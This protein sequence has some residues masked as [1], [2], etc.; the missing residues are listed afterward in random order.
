VTP[1][2]SDGTLD[3]RS[4]ETGCFEQRQS[5]VN[6]ELART[7][8]LHEVIGRPGLLSVPPQV[9]E[10]FQRPDRWKDPADGFKKITDDPHAP[11]GRC[12]P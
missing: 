11:D 12:N 9:Q 3:L 8:V 1:A 4:D 5:F 7:H 2:R 10:Q 6:G